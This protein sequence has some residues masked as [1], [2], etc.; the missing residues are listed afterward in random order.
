VRCH[1][2]K[3]VQ[4]DRAVTGSGR[5][6]RRGHGRDVTQPAGAARTCRLPGRGPA[7]SAAVV[8]A[9]LRVGVVMTVYGGVVEVWRNGGGGWRRRREAVTTAGRLMRRK[10]MIMM[11]MPGDER[12]LRRQH[13]RKLVLS[14]VAVLVNVGRRNSAFRQRISDVTTPLYI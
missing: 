12:R 7:H 13:R 1:Q 3:R 5:S 10:M 11:M 4:L 2:L 6:R 14:G 9:L 8:D